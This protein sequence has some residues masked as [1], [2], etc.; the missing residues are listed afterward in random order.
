MQ[1]AQRMRVGQ[2]NESQIEKDERGKLNRVGVKVRETQGRTAAAD[3][4]Q[5]RACRTAALPQ[6]E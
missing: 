2:D 5:A 1:V 6:P 4:R 3:G